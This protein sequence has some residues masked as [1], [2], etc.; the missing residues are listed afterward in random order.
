MNLIHQMIK[1]I[2]HPKT[3][4]LQ[5]SLSIVKHPFLNQLKKY[6]KIDSSLRNLK[7]KIG[8]NKI[9]K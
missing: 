3:Y 8:N 7:T 1:L 9:K 6:F 4:L 2:V 5:F